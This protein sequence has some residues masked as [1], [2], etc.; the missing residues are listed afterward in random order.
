MAPDAARL[1]ARSNVEYLHKFSKLVWYLIMMVQRLV[2][3][4]L[5]FAAI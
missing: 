3:W 5:R 1:E 2:F 4:C